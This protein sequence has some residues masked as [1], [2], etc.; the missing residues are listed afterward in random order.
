MSI[1]PGG[2]KEISSHYWGKCKGSEGKKILGGFNRK[3]FQRNKQLFKGTMVGGS[4]IWDHS[5]QRGGGVC[6]KSKGWS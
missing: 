6:G 3:R 1:S 4:L 5:G 2:G